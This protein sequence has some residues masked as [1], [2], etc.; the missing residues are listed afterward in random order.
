MVKCRLEIFDKESLSNE[1][2]SIISALDALGQLYGSE[3]LEVGIL[4]LING[5]QVL[6]D[7]PDYGSIKVRLVL[8]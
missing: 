1:Y 7:V 6:M 3:I 5:E 8:L 4:P 2:D